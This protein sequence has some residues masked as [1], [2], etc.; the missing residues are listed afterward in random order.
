MTKKLDRA[1]LSDFIPDSLFP[2]CGRD[3]TN[4]ASSLRVVVLAVKVVGSLDNLPV[5]Y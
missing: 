2:M 3:K 5:G 1:K 4:P